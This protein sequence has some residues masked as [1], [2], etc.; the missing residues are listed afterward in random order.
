MKYKYKIFGQDTNLHEGFIEDV[1]RDNVISKLQAGGNIII[2]VEEALV[3]ESY[4]ALDKF[5]KKISQKDLVLATRQLATLIGG[6]V[7]ILRAIR[8]LSSE[9]T[10]VGLGERF[11]V[12]GDDLQSGMQVYKALSRHGDIFDSFYISM[13][14]SGEETGKL[15]ESFEYL[16]DYI[17][18]NYELVQKTKKALTY[19]IFV[20]ITFFAVMMIMSL[21]VLPKLVS[22]I[23]E[24]GQELPWF[25]A[26]MISA[27]NLI[28][29][30]YYIIIPAIGA[31]AYYFVQFGR[32]PAGRAYYDSVKLKMP[33]LGGL[34]NKLYLSRFAD[35]IDTMISSG[36]P[37]VQAL[38]ITA[39]VVDNY[40]YK[41]MFERVAD[42]VKQGVSLS[43]ALSEEP[44][45]PNIMVQMARI[46]EET[47]EL[48]Y[49]LKNVATF[50]KRELE[51]TIESTIALVEPIMIVALGGGV[52]LLMASVLLPMY[53][54]ASS[55]Q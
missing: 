54:I 12:I 31:I 24:Q 6:G 49:M 55:I 19:P 41:K 17:E 14:H 34:Y 11:K 53:N 28:K 7:Q 13:V 43:R 22:L 26:L 36:V 50:Y 46:G 39:E 44:M 40:V 23:I 48:G 42:K 38:Q 35:N 45:I 52:G 18:R 47:G 33:L 21:F 25:T 51:R 15:K 37:I 9:A 32:T 27:S 2:D 3:S 8:L 5:K 29:S 4:S 16:A 20:I 30:Y 1:S 10:S